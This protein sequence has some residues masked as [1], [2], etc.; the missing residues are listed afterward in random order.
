MKFFI[1]TLGISNDQLRV[2]VNDPNLTPIDK[3]TLNYYLTQVSDFNNNY[4]TTVDSLNSVACQL[5]IT[6]ENIEHLNLL[7]LA[8]LEKFHVTDFKEYAKFIL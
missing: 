8:S 5:P 1:V 4:V 3:I 7:C 6:P 2:T